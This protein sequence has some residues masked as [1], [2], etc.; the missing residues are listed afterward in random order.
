MFNSLLSLRPV[1]RGLRRLLGGATL[2]LLLV[3][4]APQAQAQTVYGLNTSVP[5]APVLLTFSTAAPGVPTT[6]PV[7]GITAGQTLVGLDSRPATGE[8]FAMGYNFATTE[9]RLYTIVPATG[10][11]TAIGMGSILLPL[12]GIGAR[13]SFDFNPTVDRIRVVSSNTANYRLNPITGGVAAMDTNLSLPA[14]TPAIGAAAYTN[15]FIAATSTTL[16]DIDEST[17]TLYTQ[18]PPNNGNLVTPTLITNSSVPLLTALN[19]GSIDINTDPTTGAQGALLGVASTAT[20]AFY[21]LTLTGPTAGNASLIATLPGAVS[22]ITFAIDRTAPAST[23]QLVYGVSATSN[24]VTFRSDTPGFIISATPIT[25]VTTGQTLIG[26]DFRPNTGQLFGLGYDPTVAF[27]AINSQLYTINTGTG[28]ATA[29]GAA[30]ALD[31]GGATDQIAFDFNP[32]VDRIRVEG[33]NDN[34][35]RLNPNTGGIAAPDGTLSYAAGDAGTGQ[36]PTVGTAAYVNS[37]VGATS[38]GL[39]T[40]DHALG[41]V[42][43][44]NPANS[45]TLTSSRTLQGVNGAATGG[46]IAPLNDLDV[47]FDGTTN[48]AYLAAAAAATPTNSHL[49]SLGA[50]GNSVAVQQ[51]TDLGS[52]GV[53]SGIS[54]RDIS[55]A[56]A[57]TSTVA[58][59]PGAVTGQLVYGVAS[60]NLI[61][62]DSNNP[63]V[64]RSAVNITGLPSATGVAQTIAGADFRPATGELFALG[65]DA[66]NQM[67][68]LYTIN[69]T[70]GA[71]TAVGSLNAY[72]LG[73]SASAIGFDFNPTVDRIRV[74]SA[75]NQANLR[76]NP[77]DGTITT[78]GTLTNLGGSTPAISGVAYLNN[79]NNASTGTTLYGYDQA[80][81]VL[82]R[83]TNANAGTYQD[84]GPSGIAVNT[85]GG[86]DLDIYT[87]SPAGTNSAFAAASLT[88]STADNF[89]SVNLTSGALTSLGRI[90]SGSNL[91]G[92][93]VFLTPSPLTNLITWT[94]ITSTDYGTASNWQPQVVPGTTSN[95]LIPG[96]TP[97]QPEV[98][99]AAG[100]QNVTLNAGATLTT[101]GASITVSGSI[102]NAGTITGTGAGGVIMD[103]AVAQNIGG[104]GSNAFRDLTVRNTSAAGVSLTGPASVSRQ[105]VLLTGTLTTTGQVLTIRSDATG[106]GLVNKS[107][108]GSLIGP[109]TVQRYIYGTTNTGAGYRHFSSPVVGDQ[110]STLATTGFAPVLTTGYNTA[111][112]ARQTSPFPNVFGYDQG[113]IATQTAAMLATDLGDFDKGFVVPTATTVMDQGVGYT[114]NIGATRTPD[115]TGGLVTGTVTRS[116]LQYGTSGD[117]GWQFLGNPFAAP[118]SWDNVVNN[119]GLTNVGNAVYVFKS[120]TQYNGTYSTYLPGTGG[121]PGM[122]INGGVSTLPV[123]QAY[124][125]RVVGQGQT[126]SVAMASADQLTTDPGTQFQRGTADLRPQLTL[127]LTNSTAA[128]QTAIYFEA[129][130]TAAADAR[131]DAFALPATNGLTLTSVVGAQAMGINGLPLLTGTDVRVP[132]QVAAA[133]A[134]QYTL[135]VDNLAHLP[136]G[137]RAYLHDALTGTFTDLTT[138]PRVALTLAA[139]APAAGRYAVLF[140]TQATALATAPAAL[141][142]LASVYPNP[143]HGTASLLLPA[144]L[145]G[146]AATTVQVV[147]NLGRAVLTRTLAAGTNELLELPLSGLAPGIYSVQAHTAA[148]LVAKRLVVE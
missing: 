104:T 110:I 4:A 53:G 144:A 105:L 107:A 123:A 81:N 102:A 84:Q 148:G 14:G 100:A 60:G 85:A 139:N 62:F 54:V 57:A 16:Y 19:Q 137:Y 5:A 48:L 78:D 47:Y 40:L 130:A 94:G 29:V 146:N 120:T 98:S 129:G 35:Y 74:V 111:T 43:L 9:T 32:T 15:S 92:T 121:N 38:T 31:L 58:V 17:S 46:A 49:Y 70:S 119:G 12:G 10:V 51:A 108:G 72:P 97:F 44:Q 37:Y 143:A 131:Y 56:L 1:R 133:T 71:V 124:Y 28:A 26:T 87:S 125:V 80:R 61:S 115:F 127:S 128:L 6:V 109:L 117:A 136:T 25:G 79:D 134:G 24:L 126:G 18:N 30:I 88:G 41:F 95:I 114:V 141:A 7:T 33:T 118:L 36:N 145:R 142:Q 140:S 76:V 64:I 116:N 83:S 22:D 135:A 27:P 2:G 89:Y 67:G 101:M 3:G 68:Q 11:A 52:I 69:L 73:A 132:L 8:L 86:V 112:L 75:T 50:L 103:A 96:A 147:D 82:L 93:A 55:V 34:N 77:T 39:Y 45:G 113:R 90:G 63:G 23:G 59:A 13:I 91:S 106:T 99:A 42:S 21:A 138:T 65:Y 122:G 66:A 20:T